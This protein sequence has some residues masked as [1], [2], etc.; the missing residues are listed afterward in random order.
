MKMERSHPIKAEMSVGNPKSAAKEP[1]N[2]DAI[3]VCRKR[4]EG[5]EVVCKA[6]PILSGPKVIG[7]RG[8]ERRG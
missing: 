1:I 2:L 4:S 7:Y 3:L 8:F 6:D 5:Q